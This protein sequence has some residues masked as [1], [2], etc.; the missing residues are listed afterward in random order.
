MCWWKLGGPQLLPFFGMLVGWHPWTL[1]NCCTAMPSFGHVLVEVGG[2][3]LLPLLASLVCLWGGLPGPGHYVSCNAVLCFGHALGEASAVVLAAMMCVCASYWGIPTAGSICFVQTVVMQKQNWSG[4]L[5]ALP[6][7]SY[8]V[9]L[10]SGW[11]H[12]WLT[13]WM[14]DRWAWDFFHAPKEAVALQDCVSSFHVHA[15]SFQ[16]ALSVSVL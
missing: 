15:W 5:A 9:E 14:K 11:L 2:P 8:L 6:V 3:Q 16:I 1:C 13:M 4:V 12:G 10:G 7:V